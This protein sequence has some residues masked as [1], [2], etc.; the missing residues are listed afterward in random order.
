MRLDTLLFKT[1]VLVHTLHV[2]LRSM[3]MIFQRRDKCSL[4]Y[5]MRSAHAVSVHT[6]LAKASN[7]CVSF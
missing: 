2:F 7:I 1:L 3:K 4:A 5:D 6:D